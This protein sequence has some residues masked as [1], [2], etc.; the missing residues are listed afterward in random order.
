MISDYFSRRARQSV[1]ALAT[2]MICTTTYPS[3]GQA[4]ELVTVAGDVLLAPHGDTLLG[5]TEAGKQI[6]LV[7]ALPS[8]DP[9]GAAA[10][11]NAVST[12]G[13][14]LYHRT[15]TPDQYAARFGASSEDYAALVAWA[16][17]SGLKPGEVF[18]ART[19]LPLTGTASSLQA[20]FGITFHSYRKASGDTYYAADRA[21]RLPAALAGKVSGVIGLSSYTHFAPL[22]R[23][24]PAGVHPNLSGTGPGDG[25]SAADLRSIYNIRPQC[26]GKKT[27]QIALFEE[28]GFAASDVTTYRQQMHI[29]NVPVTGRSVDGSS[30]A[31]NDPGIE[32]EAVLD[33]DM[34]LAANPAV[35]QITVYEDTVGSFQGALI[36]SLAAMANDNS[37][38]IISISYGQDEALQSAVP[39]AAENTIFTQM[40]AQG[41]AVFVSAGDSGA[42][43]NNPPGLNVFDPASQPLVTAVGGTTLFTGPGESY[44]SE[45]AWNELGVHQGATGGGIS[46]VWSIPGYQL[47]K[48]KSVAKAN[49]GSSNFR[50]V[51]DVSVVADPATGVAVY[52]QLNG[53]WN[54]VGGTSV[55][56]PLW[57]GLY[58]V[59]N[60]NSVALGWGNLGFANP[61][62]YALGE[63]NTVGVNGIITPGFIDV[64]DGTN[65]NANLYRKAGFTAGPGYDNTTGMGSP[66]ANNLMIDVTLYTSFKGFQL[67][68]PTDIHATSVTGTSITVSW[69]SSSSSSDFLV[70]GDT[71]TPFPPVLTNTTSATITGLTPN[72]YY[73]VYVYPVSKVGINEVASPIYVR[74]AAK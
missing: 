69:V 48:G 22:L 32:L 12:P 58:S 62:L 3:A 17:A 47:V 42:Y 35:K 38:Q 20:A 55:G 28:G 46:T 64:I 27:Q 65:G 2:A 52:S 57:A 31:I 10:F 53:G 72:T 67:P 49:R 6:T 25:F 18:A 74:T 68:R 16:R 19:I 34:V 26:C 24:L 8:R 13:N 59:A 71:N 11:A 40:A 4:S 41:Q 14:P 39:I 51:P 30:L 7:L 63:S 15:L 60:G 37:S 23:R 56:A 45:Q 9:A 54:V 29:P 36:D 21:P 73:D 61:T 66:D 5:E 50:N 44:Y 1:L 33:I 70:G 43:G